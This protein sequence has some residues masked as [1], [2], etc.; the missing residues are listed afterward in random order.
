[1]EPVAKFSTALEGQPGVGRIY[2]IGLEEWEPE[3]EPRAMY[4]VV[5]NQWCVGHLTDA[6][7]V[8][9]LRRCVAA[10]VPDDQHGCGGLIVVK[11]NL[12]RGDEDEFDGLD[13]S[14]TRYACQK[15]SSAPFPSFPA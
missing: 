13:N 6:Q 3:P 4:D 5:W 8:Q 7:L 12:S 9:Y 15:L 2:S 1:M 14:V 11:E 10:L